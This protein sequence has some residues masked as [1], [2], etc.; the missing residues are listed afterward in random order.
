MGSGF[1]I[2]SVRG[3]KQYIIG[4]WFDMPWVRGSEYH[5]LRGSSKIPKAGSIYHGQGVRYTMS[6]RGHTKYHK[7]AVI[8]TMSR[9][10]DIP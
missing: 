1:G 10:Y 3:F 2:P 6:L 5:E 4:S 7:Q 9:E 8:Y